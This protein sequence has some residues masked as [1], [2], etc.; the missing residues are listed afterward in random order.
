VALRSLPPPCDA[1]QKNKCRKEIPEEEMLVWTCSKCERGGKREIELG[2]YT[3][4]MF[5]WIRLRNAGYPVR[6]ND[7]TP[8]EWN[9]LGLIEEMLSG[10]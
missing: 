9:D 7:L 10:Q 1:I 5:R 3:Q 2:E 4:K 6:P 8:E